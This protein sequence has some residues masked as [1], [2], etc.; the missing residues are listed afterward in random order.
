[1]R[2]LIHPSN[3]SAHRRVQSIA[4]SCHLL[5]RDISACRVQLTGCAGLAA[6][7]NF[8][9]ISGDASE[10]RCA[11]ADI[12]QQMPMVSS[13]ARDVMHAG[14]PARKDRRGAPRAENAGGMGGAETIA[15]RLAMSNTSTTVCQLRLCARG[16]ASV[17]SRENLTVGDLPFGT[18][19]PRRAPV[20]PPPSGSTV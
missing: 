6:Q 19:S 7:M 1:M 11:L 4:A 15:E 17:R 3:V 12:N 13:A 2:L 8:S 10:H 20:S 14:I 16:G 9:V 18:W 5:R